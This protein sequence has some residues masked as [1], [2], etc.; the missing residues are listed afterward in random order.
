MKHL[1]KF[2]L[3]ATGAAMGITF[4]LPA[5]AQDWTL[6]PVV[7]T[8]DLSVQAVL[9]NI[10]YWVLG[11]AG[12]VAILFLI[13]GGLQ[14]ITSSGNDKRVAAAKSTLLYAVIGL[15]VILLSFVVVAFINA[16]IGKV[17]Q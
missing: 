12:A 3:A 5:F 10:I 13:I 7:P 4:A 14:Y 16:N 17:V 11:F 2:T 6:T 15:I 1:N 8:G 9:I